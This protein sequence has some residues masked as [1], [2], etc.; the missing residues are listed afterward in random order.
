MDPAGIQLSLPF[1][2]PPTFENLLLRRRTHGML[3]V[4]PNRMLKRGWQVK[5]LPLSG[6]RQLIIPLCLNEA[7]EDIKLSLIDW[8]L[9]PCRPRHARKKIIRLQRSLLENYLESTPNAPR[10]V[11]RFNPA[12]FSAD[13]NDQGAI[14]DLKEVFYAV[15]HTYFKGSIMALVRW[16]RADSKTSYHTVKTDATG[17]RINLI[18]IA[19]AYNHPDV[20]RFALEGIM[21]HEMLHIA[22][23][24]YKKNGRRIIH[25][26]EFRIGEKKFNRHREWRTWEREKLPSLVRQSCIKKKCRRT[27]LFPGSIL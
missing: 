18:T 27:S 20:P 13:A 26:K 14:Y 21:H 9:L 16:G 4:I 8:A 15:N 23:P 12:T 22:V 1:F 17:S 24:P 19:G 7:P 10:R 5:V 6:K 3:S 11:S 2:D 25:G